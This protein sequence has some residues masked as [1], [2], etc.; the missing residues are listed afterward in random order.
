M[1]RPDN[2]ARASAPEATP[3]KIEQQDAQQQDAHAEPLDPFAN[4][5]A[6]IKG[7]RLRYNQLDDDQ[8]LV[9]DMAVKEGKNI[10]CVGGAGTGKSGTCEVIMDELRDL[11]RK[12]VIV[13]PSGTSAV[14]VRAQTLH[15]FFRL[16]FQSN[17]S[18]DH[19]KRKMNTAVRERLRNVDSLVI[20]EI[21][22]VSCEMF[23]RMDELAKTARG[24]TRPFGGM[25]VLVFGDFL[26][27]PP[28]KPQEY[29]YQ[30]GCERK[31]VTLP[32]YGRG[33]KG[34]MVWECPTSAEHRK[35]EDSDKM[36]AFQSS[37]WPLV[38]FEYL[39]LNQV[40]RQ[41]D[42]VFLALLNKL[43][44][45]QPFTSKQIDLLE[46]HPCEVTNAVLILPH[47]N[48]AYTTNNSCFDRLPG[49]EHRFHCQDKFIWERDLHPELKDI[50]SAPSAALSSHAYERWVLLKV[51]QPVIL[52]RNLD[53][54]KGL[55]NGSQG[56][57][58][59]FVRYTMKQGSPENSQQK[60]V[61][62]RAFAVTAWKISCVVRDSPISPSSSS[63][64]WKPRKSS[65][66]IAPSWSKGSQ[67]HTP[68]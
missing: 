26:Q 42:A 31:K 43:R 60:K 7:P 44:K 51:D 38:N 58:V 39:P 14:N 17:K 10:C 50:N 63:T 53:V 29:C 25:Q 32:G 65:I 49:A 27:L 4:N 21:S 46:E 48:D 2:K 1:P 61:E 62:P 59:D 13:A 20:D 8:K 5:P 30:C 66:R 11:G 68:S 9:V 28:V 57:I 52:Q 36:W 15:S 12:V 56:V 37:V 24:D 64:T 33:K 34:P 16:G 40:H 6:Y 55:I 19:Y 18:I 35:I 3:I 23:D 41:A 54:D 22:M 45:G 47:R 67:R